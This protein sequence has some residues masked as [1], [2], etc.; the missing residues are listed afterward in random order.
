M[1]SEVG[2]L[3]KNHVLCF[4]L[5]IDANKVVSRVFEY[6]EFDENKNWEF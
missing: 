3:T 5:S 4:M 1:K 6:V 2:F